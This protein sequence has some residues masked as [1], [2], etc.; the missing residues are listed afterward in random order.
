MKEPAA[1]ALLTDLYQ[2]TML[3]SY[4]EHGLTDTAVFEFFVRK[5]PKARG[6]LLTAGLEQVLDYLEDLRFSPPELEW[7]RASGRFSG[8]FVDRLAAFR[9]TGEVHA[10]PEGTVCFTNE[11]LLRV[12][13]PL[14]EAQLVE[15]RVINLLHFQSLIAT[16][17]ARMALAAPGKLLVDFGL[18]RTHGAEAG[19]LAGRA[20]YLAGLTGTSTVEAGRRF[21]VPVFG[22]MAHSYIEAHADE[23]EAFA[24]FA[25]SHPG[26]VVL[27]ID[28]YDTEAGARKVAALA[29]RLAAEGISVKGVRID[30]GDLADHARKVRAILDEAGLDGVTI[31]ASGSLDE[32]A[33]ERF[34]AAGAP[35]DGYG[36][37]TRMNTSADA[38]YLDCAYKLQ[39]YAGTPRR[40]R[41]EGK[42]TWPGRK[43]VFRDFAADG[44]IA[45]DTLTTH[46]DPL[47]GTP[48][49][50]PMMAAG[51]R[52]GP[53]PPLEAVRE[54]AAEALTTLPPAARR[55]KDPE[56]VP[57]RV[58]D[59][60]RALARRAD[61]AVGA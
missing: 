36:I 16:K 50:E 5:L 35:I 21:G 17:A 43:Q 2:L 56:P 55:L 24:H 11:P 48:L 46:D 53:S 26:N 33:L 27:L 42:A 7:M 10:V 38:P 37:G 14:P 1:P 44:T 61:E 29:P 6:F 18:R 45:G 51:R 39:E 40:K 34:T 58:A 28:T 49:V 8:D 57:V 4:Y 19:L 15:T 12:T 31:F 52:L 59:A 3:Q 20:G 54:R 32:Y 25:R 9:F 30:S 41:S 22:T 60:L 13:A 23:A 47:S